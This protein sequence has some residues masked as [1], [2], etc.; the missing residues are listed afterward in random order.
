MIIA[1]IS[2]TNVK[3]DGTPRQWDC[4]EYSGHHHGRVIQ[5]IEQGK[6]KQINLDT[7]TGTV[8]SHNEEFIFENGSQKFTIHYMLPF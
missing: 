2:G 7:F 6:I 4:V 3:V 8:L 1:L 5:V